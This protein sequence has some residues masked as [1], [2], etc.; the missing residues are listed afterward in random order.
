M[1]SLVPWAVNE[2]RGGFPVAGR[3]S[4]TA[5]GTTTSTEVVSLNNGSHNRCTASRPSNTPGSRLIPS[6]CCMCSH[7]VRD[8][9]LFLDWF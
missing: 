6:Q 7:Q 9:V 5:S 4:W 1:P 3:R 2:H 8:V